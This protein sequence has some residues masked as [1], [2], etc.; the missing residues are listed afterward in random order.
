MEQLFI[1][2]LSA[3]SFVT[4]DWRAAHLFFVPLRCTAYRK[5]VK[6]LSEGVAFAQKMARKMMDEVKQANPGLWNT[7][8]G[9]NH[10]YICAHDMGARVMR[11]V[12]EWTNMIALVNTASTEPGTHFISHKD[13]SLPNHPSRGAVS[14]DNVGRGSPG[15]EKRKHLMFFAGNPNR[16]AAVC[17]AG[18]RGG[19]SVDH[20]GG[21]GGG[22]GGH[23]SLRGFTLDVTEWASTEY[24]V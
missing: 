4:A 1:D 19:Y 15:F 18:G 16:C 11:D 20:W 12:P 8:L 14:W 10:F 2:L 17:V 23:V 7:T 5:S 22:G 21:G 3:S 13:V 24:R 6:E 9:K